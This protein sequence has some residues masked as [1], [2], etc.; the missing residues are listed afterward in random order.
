MITWVK[1][2]N[3]A[4]V[5]FEASVNLMDDDI[6]EIVHNIGNYKTNQEF[7]TAY[8][9]AHEAFKKEPWELSKANPTY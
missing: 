6:K 3:G 9:K 5:D 4:L 8:E 1:N 2:L 7:F